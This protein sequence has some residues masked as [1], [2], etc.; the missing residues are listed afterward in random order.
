[1]SNNMCNA[2]ILYD[3]N[4][5]VDP[6]SWDSKFNP[7]SLH[8]SMEHLATDA[9]NIKESLWCIGKYILNKKI[10]QGKANSIADLRGVGEATWNFISSIY[11]AEW[12]EL[13]VDKNNFSFRQKVKMQFNSLSMGA[14][15]SKKGKV[16]A[17]LALILSLSP[18]IPVKPLKETNTISKYFKKL[19]EN[20]GKKLY[21]QASVL[22]SNITREI[23][24]IK[25][26]FLK[27]QDKKIK[28]IQKI[29]SNENKLKPCLNMTI[30]GPSRKQVIILINTKNRNCFMKELSAHVYNRVLKNIKL[31]IIAD[32]ICSDNKDII[33]TTNKVVS[34]LDLQTIERYIKNVNN[35]ESNQ[36][37]VPRLPQS[38][39]Y[40][41]IISISFFLEDMNT[42]ISSDVS[43]AVHTGVKVCGV[44]SEMS[45]L[46]E[47][48]WLQLM[49]CTVCLLRGHNFRWWEESPRWKWVLNG[50]S[51]LN[52][53][54]RVQ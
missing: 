3:N 32:F 19:S 16:T 35:I 22:S 48:P 2:Q 46:V 24:K 25:E 42:P 50:V 12:D 21:A 1:M 39:S 20:K 26:M 37:E 36:V 54:D 30:K 23:L 51:P 45:R 5:A 53:R 6:E 49:C 33:I 13:I 52:T 27:L 18:L 38:K 15:I 29:I 11:K 47:Q 43:G 7:I 34:M 10:E 14:S 28:Y 17:K 8:G 44:D 41:K 4:Q 31:E 40:L 9:I